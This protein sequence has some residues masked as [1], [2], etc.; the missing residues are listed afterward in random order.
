MLQS[1]MGTECRVGGDQIPAS[2]A[3]AE[4]QGIGALDAGQP[5]SAKLGDGLEVP[6][7][8]QARQLSRAKSRFGPASDAPLARGDGAGVEDAA[9]QGGISVGLGEDVTFKEG[10]RYQA[11]LVIKYRGP[12]EA[13]AVGCRV[14]ETCERFQDRFEWRKGYAHQAGNPGPPSFASSED[15][16][17]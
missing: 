11:Q 3:E 16:H 13:A 5:E 10:E 14:P 9:G 7:P 17:C 12:C 15:E 4:Q 6:D 1:V 2:F 8:C